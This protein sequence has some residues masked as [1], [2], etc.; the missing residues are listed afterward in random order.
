MHKPKL[1]FKTR[2]GRQEKKHTDIP[3]TKGKSVSHVETVQW[4]I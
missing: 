4:L 3:S 1:S 2:V